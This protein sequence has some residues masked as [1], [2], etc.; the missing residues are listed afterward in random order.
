MCFWEKD[1][2][3]YEV[4]KKYER[5]LVAIGIDFSREDVQ[6]ILEGYTY[7]LE[8]ALRRTIEYVLW[9]NEQER[10]VFPN[11]ILVQA[12]QNRWKPRKWSEEYLEL[13]KLQSIGQK[14]RNGD[15]KIWGQDLCNQLVADVFY[16]SGK[17][18][19]KFTNGKEML[20]ETAWYWG[21]ERVLSYATT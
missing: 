6:D 4:F 3:E 20:V 16:D 1:S 21:W 12:L 7:G 11:A 9:L 10:E 13:P 2:V 17:E 19:I 18:F 15:A 5:A 14:W 8:D